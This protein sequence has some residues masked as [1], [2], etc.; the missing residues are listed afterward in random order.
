MFGKHHTAEAKASM[1]KKLS[2]KNN[3]MYG[4]VNWNA[5][6]NA[7]KENNM[8]VRQ[9]DKQGN[10]VKEYKTQDMENRQKILF[11]IDSIL[12]CRLPFTT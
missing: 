12:N 3:P 9:F 2:G 1:S 8:P 4:V 5:I 7:A 10:F 6:N 11:I